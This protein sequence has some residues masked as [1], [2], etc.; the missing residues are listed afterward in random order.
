M[1][2]GIERRGTLTIDLTMRR[3]GKR[4]T[5]LAV[6]E[7]TKN[8]PA[9]RAKNE[10]EKVSQTYWGKERHGRFDIF[11]AFT[12]IFPFWFFIRVRGPA[13]SALA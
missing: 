10:R 5:I 8:R 9:G 3:K 6:E 4:A 12:L 11:C 2:V 13:S 1:R 7:K